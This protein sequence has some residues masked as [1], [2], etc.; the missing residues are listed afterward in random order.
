MHV[1]QASFTLEV[2]A[3][4]APAL[5]ISLLAIDAPRSLILWVGAG[6]GAAPSLGALVAAVPAGGATSALLDAPG[7]DADEAA[8][9]ARALAARAKK[10]V[11]LAWTPELAGAAREEV[12][13]RAFAFALEGGAAAEA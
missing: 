7:G 4:G 1:R 9:F 5:L 13:R 3:P 8:A 12:A 10:L 6:A 11:L 2:D